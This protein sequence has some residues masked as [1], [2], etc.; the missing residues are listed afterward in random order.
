MTLY[1][2]IIFDFFGTLTNQNC[3]PEDKIVER[4]KLYQRKD[5][6]YEQVEDI[7]CGTACPTP[8]EDEDRKAYYKTLIEKLE[9]PENEATYR[10]L[11]EIT[12]GDIQGEQLVEG[13]RTIIDF[14]RG[15]CEKMGM[16][17]DLPNP[18]YD[19]ST[20]WGLADRFDF[21]HLSY[22]PQW[23]N[24]SYNR[25]LKPE[26][27]IFQRVLSRLQVKP[28]ETIMIGNSFHSDI[29]PARRLGMRAIL[30]D[31]HK[32]Y[33]HDND[34]ITNLQELKNV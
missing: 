6:S 26:P 4:Y 32:K 7:V 9:L 13:A 8:F 2:G 11:H 23:V 28:Q 10:T 19:L 25:V 27:A 30:V 21:R 12:R 5:F 14:A 17:S 34:R 24:S 20:K 29:Q 22:D 16:I 1:K 18:D 3:A 15:K 33:P 31:Y